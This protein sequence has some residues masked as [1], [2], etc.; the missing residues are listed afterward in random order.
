M[1]SVLNGSPISE[2]DSVASLGLNG[3]HNSLGYRVAEIER[4]LHSGGRWFETATTPSGETHVADAIGT[5][6]GAFQIDAGDGT[7]G[8][9]VQI[10]GSSDT[11]AVA[12]KAYFDPHEIVMEAVERAF[13]Y[14]VQMGRGASGAAAISAG[15]YTEF[16]YAAET[17]RDTGIL[18]VQTGRAP[19]GSLVWA[20]CMCP[21]QNTATMDFYVGLHEYEG[22]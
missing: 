3:T 13:T 11:P 22:N 10:L 21:G 9:W 7:W 19:A 5:G 20:R 1:A 18:E 15:T 16:V 12:G 14:F 4:H 8:T 2:I 6:G 17:S